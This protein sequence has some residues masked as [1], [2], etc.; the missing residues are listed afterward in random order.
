MIFSDYHVHTFYCDG[1]NS[2][3]EVVISAIEKGVKNLG[4]S[5][6]SYTSFD[7]SY[8]IKKEKIASYKKEIND[9]KEK[10]KVKINILCGS[11]FDFYSDMPKEG[12]D[13]LIGS[14]HYIKIGEDFID[15]DNTAKILRDAADKY[16]SGDVYSLAE[17]YYK[18]MADIIEKT[19]ADIIGHFN[20]IEK[21]EDREPLFDTESERYKKA[22]QGAADKLILSKKP[23]EINT[24]AISRGYKKEPYPSMEMIE[25]ID[26]KGGKFILSSD[27]HEKSTLL[28]EFSKWEKD[29]KEKG[30]KIINEGF[31]K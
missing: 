6:H 14:C 28:Y 15:V 22:W 21:F 1:K 11:E 31:G 20:L 3:E 19:D 9:L 18:D 12:F 29:L 24:G 10:Y 23:F 16:F 5:V 26:K 25:Y 13:F 4:F 2:P 7:E 8:C 30:I 27:S 17:L